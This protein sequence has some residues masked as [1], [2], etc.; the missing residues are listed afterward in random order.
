MDRH[1]LNEALHRIMSPD[2]HGASVIAFTDE[3]DGSG[4]VLWS[5]LERDGVE[6]ISHRW[7][8]RYIGGRPTD[9][10]VHLHGG[11][12]TMER[13]AAE[14]DFINRGEWRAREALEKEATR[15]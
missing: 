15:G 3:M 4:L 9:D 2:C 6:F 11:Y 8:D 1:T 7:F 5:R 10:G 14:A 13:F 12:Y